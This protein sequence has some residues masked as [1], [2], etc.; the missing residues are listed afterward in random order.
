MGSRLFL[1]TPA[2]FSFRHTVYGHGW[3]ELLP[4]Q[5]D[6]VNWR[7]SFV[8]VGSK[9]PVS[10]IVYEADGGVEIELGGKRFKEDEVIRDV[11]HMLRLDDPLEEF[12]S[13][14]DMEEGL[15]GVSSR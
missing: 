15:H 14:T 9:R 11:R 10:G 2:N 13:L 5:L 7:L 4:F 8:H 3:S 6:D 1:A 12:Y